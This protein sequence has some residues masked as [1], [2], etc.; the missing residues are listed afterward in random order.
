M[1]TRRYDIDNIR[2]LATLTIFL[3]HNARLFDT[4]D[5]HVKNF[6]T[7]VPCTIFVGIIDAWVMPLFFLLSGMAA[8][9]SLSRRTWLEF[10]RERAL[11][12]LLPLYTVGVVLLLP[13]QFALDGV[14]HGMSFGG[15]LNG[16]AGFFEHSALGALPPF[17]Y[18][19][20]GH[21]WF[22][23]FLFYISLVTL[24][25]FLWMGTGGGDRVRKRIVTA[26]SGR[27]GPFLFVVPLFAALMGLSGH[28]HGEHSWAD[29][30]YFALY[31]FVGYILA[32][33][34]RFVPALQS[35]AK[36]GL[37]IGVLGFGAEGHFILKMGYAT[38][39]QSFT[40]LL[41]YT[42]FQL[43]MS[44]QTLGWIIAILGYGSKFLSG[45]YRW[46][47][48]GNEAVLPFYILHQT[49]ILVVGWYV[50]QLDWGIPAKY[51][52]NAATSF[53][54][55]LAAYLVL[56]RPFNPVRFL[57]GMHSKKKLFQNRVMPVS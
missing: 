11:R 27:F 45:K 17:V 19:F 15:W 47:V 21:L 48:P 33:D 14:T 36:W 24:P 29:F 55:I 56:I 8:W 30:V 31:S 18:F 51:A 12:L 22:L 26:C 41:P 9:Y 1:K 43:T 16:C 32:S 23:W 52:L 54:L 42:L 13:P 37:L 46:T 6:R 2:I 7:A 34:K 44:L 4:L 49:V 53:A 20:N 3:F 5:W 39:T 40:P 25:V 28:F 10:L 35:C 50:V 38:N 57:F